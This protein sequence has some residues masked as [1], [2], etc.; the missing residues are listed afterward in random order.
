LVVVVVGRGRV[1][2]VV[3]GG[4]V[5]VVVVVDGLGKVVVVVA[6]GFTVVVVP[7]EA[8]K[9][10]TGPVAGMLRADAGG[11]DAIRRATL[12]PAALT[13]TAAR[14]GERDMNFD[15]RVFDTTGGTPRPRRPEAISEVRG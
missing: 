3:R 5:V 4:C 14:R 15:L 7:L 10:P 11:A 13:A 2:V 6:V 1:V 12:R 9:A 8:V